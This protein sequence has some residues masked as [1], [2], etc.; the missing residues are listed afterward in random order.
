MK[1]GQQGGWYIFLSF[2]AG[3][4]LTSI[5][6][7]G[8]LEVLRPEWMVM[9]LI[10]WCLALP[11]R[12]S[13]GYGWIAGLFLDVAR[14]SL[15]GQHALA[16]SVVAYLTITLHQRIRNFPVGQQAGVVFGLVA[17]YF[18]IIAWVMGISDHAPNFSGIL[19]ASIMTAVLWPPV[20]HALRFLRRH[21]HI[22]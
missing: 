2:L 12:V 9:A 13:V 3:L 18:F 11:S 1:Q 21:F 4:L 15:L 5:P 6:L 8:W 7:P 17:A 16:M 10:Y 14:D 19:M 22:R 20:F